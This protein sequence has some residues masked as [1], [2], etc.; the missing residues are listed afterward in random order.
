[1]L[2]VTQRREIAAA[3]VYSG[4]RVRECVAFGIVMS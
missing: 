3:P 2:L 4:K 1:M